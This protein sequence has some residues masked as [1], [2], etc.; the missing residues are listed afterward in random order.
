MEDMV[1]R[2]RDR[3]YQVN[4]Q[5][6]RNAERSQMTES[7]GSTV[8]ILFARGDT[9]AMIWA[10]DSRVYRWR[11]GRLERLTRDHSMAELDAE[12][13]SGSTA[14]TR[15]VGV[16]PEVTLDVRRDRVLPGDR[17]LLCSDGLH[18]TIGDE[19]IQIWMD[20]GDVRG[21]VD[22][23]IRTTLEAGAPDNV[24]VVIAEAR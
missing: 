3:I 21:A 14:I 22:G 8:V 5:L 4:D 16:E 10:G 2:L 23:L 12:G 6:Q 24:T 19:Q 20:A 13:H 11:D 15:A 17:Y 7:C 9:C 1:E 18:H